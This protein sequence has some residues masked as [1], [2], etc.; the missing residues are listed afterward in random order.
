[1]NAREPTV[2]APAERP[3]LRP[4][5]RNGASAAARIVALALIANGRIKAVEMAALEALKA[6]EALGLSRAQWHAVIDE[7]C[8]DLL[9]ATDDAGDCAIDSAMLERVLAEV[10]DPQLQRVVLRLCAAAVHADRMVD[11]GESFVLLAALERWAV[12]VDEHALLEQLM[13]GADFQ[14]RPRGSG[15]QAA[16][17]RLRLC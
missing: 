3:V 17:R 12:N 2:H 11:D 6:H 16:S 10:D 8:A 7:L 9:R 5:A 1:M 13:Y 15:P 14:V 4:Y